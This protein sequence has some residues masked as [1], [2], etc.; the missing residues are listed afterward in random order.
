MFQKKNLIYQGR[1]VRKFNEIRDLLDIYHV[2][3]TYQVKDTV[4]DTGNDSPLSF[5]G[6]QQGMAPRAF[7]GSAGISGEDLKNY[8]IYAYETD[9]EEK[10]P[11]NLWEEVLQDV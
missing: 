5:L 3:Y 10:V 8:I 2:K 7:T 6:R 9:I 4:N 1:S 11:K